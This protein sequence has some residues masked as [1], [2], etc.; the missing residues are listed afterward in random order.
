MDSAGRLP[1][2]PDNAAGSDCE[3]QPV[4]RL[5]TEGRDAFIRFWSSLHAATF[6]ITD[7][8][9]LNRVLGMPVIRLTTTGRRTGMPRSTVLTA[10]IVEADR[11]VLVASNGGDDRDPQWYLNLLARP[12]VRVARQG[13]EV[14]MR[15]HAAQ[16]RQRS[17]LWDAI[18][19]VTPIYALHQ[20]RTS[21]ELPIVLLERR[22]PSPG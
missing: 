22:A 19:A 14:D 17:D 13:V 20:R 7:G 9:A 8:R 16:A 1:Q 15:G 18:R 2:S 6:Q 12:E 11:I 5:A 3:V 4:D 10:P 21:R